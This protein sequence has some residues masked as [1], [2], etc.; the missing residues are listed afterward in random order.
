MVADEVTFGAPEHPVL[1]VDLNEDDHVPS[2]RA[3]PREIAAIEANL[4]IANMDFADFANSA[5]ED[6]VFRGFA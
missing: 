6:G 5:G 4:S 1:L 3:L 2:F